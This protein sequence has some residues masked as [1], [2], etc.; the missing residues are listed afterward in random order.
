MSQT[1]SQAASAHVPVGTVIST[2]VPTRLDRLKWSP[3][4]WTV[5]IALGIT[6]DPRRP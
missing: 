2:N 1:S 3:W 6:W 4:H 5:V